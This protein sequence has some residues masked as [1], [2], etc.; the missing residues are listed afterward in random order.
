MS[1]DKNQP[2]KAAESQGSTPGGTM[3]AQSVREMVKAIIDE[4]VPS[5]VMAGVQA[6][7]QVTRGPDY[8]AQA[9]AAAKQQV[10]NRREC[11]DCR[12]LLKA[13]HGEHVKIV[14]YPSNVRRGKSFPGIFLNHIQYI[15]RTPNDLVTVP[16]END[17][18]YQ[19]AR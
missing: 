13:C 3:S 7:I 16:K 6:A 2:P 5:A 10:D 12:Q 19:V 17:I 14:V 18:G 8:R 1:N 4:A 9:E 15:S 11:P